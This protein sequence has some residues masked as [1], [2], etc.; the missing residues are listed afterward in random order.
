MIGV[1][2]NESGEAGAG[3]VESWAK[4]KLRAC[5]NVTRSYDLDISFLVVYVEMSVATYEVATS[6]TL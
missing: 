2:P 6:I 4:G 5:Y 3:S 1:E